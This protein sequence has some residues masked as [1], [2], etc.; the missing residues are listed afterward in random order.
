MC[1]HIFNCLL[2][3]CIDSISIW[4]LSN[5]LIA[6]H[7]KNWYWSAKLHPEGYHGFT[8]FT[9]FTLH[10]FHPSPFR[11][12][13]PRLKVTQIQPSHASSFNEWCPLFNDWSFFPNYT[14]GWK[15]ITIDWINFLLT[16]KPASFVIRNQNYSFLKH[17]KSWQPCS[18]KTMTTSYVQ[19]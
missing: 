7:L 10:P 4:V 13:W 2:K 12:W 5:S 17:L 14:S 11:F 18:Q 16:A 1:S 3:V 15:A 19:L 9:S 8:F 6:R